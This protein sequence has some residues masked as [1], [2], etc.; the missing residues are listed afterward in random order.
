MWVFKRGVSPS[1][2][3]LP[4]LLI[5]ERGT[6]GVRSPNILKEGGRGDRLLNN[7]L[8]KEGQKCVKLRREKVL[9]QETE[10]SHNQKVE[11]L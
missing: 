7:L 11:K 6:Q 3:N 1:F 4:P 8:K 5:K 10:L 9:E 2:K